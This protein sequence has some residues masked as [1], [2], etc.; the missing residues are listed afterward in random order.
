[1]QLLVIAAVV[2][3]VNL[4]PAFGPPTWAVL[5]FF[6]LHDHVNPVL[7][8][9]VGAVAAASGRMVLALVS[10][11]VGRHLPQAR[12][13]RLAEARVVIESRRRSAIA[14]LALFA[15]SPLPSAQLFIAAGLLE[16]PI[17]ALTAA[18]FAGRIVSY[19][20]YV[21]LATIADKSLGSVLGRYLGSP[22]SIAIQIV[23]L[24]LVVVLPFLNWS[25]LLRR[26]AEP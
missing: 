19:S 20:F 17:V 6:R 10:R 8:V 15:V 1:M 13:A 3:G 21:T 16:M 12:R 11:K 14:V 18:F 7:L 26:H 24:A 2:F 23:L 5:V 22:L 4:L 9:A 25:K